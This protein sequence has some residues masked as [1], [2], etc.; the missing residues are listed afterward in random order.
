MGL[1]G[2]PI[3]VE[4]DLLPGLH[5]FTIVGLP[6]KAVE[7]A[8]E[9]VSSAIKNTGFRPPQKKNHR[10]TVNLAPAELQKEGSIFDFAIALGYLLES[11]QINFDPNGKF[12][13]G[14]LA[15]DGTL[16]PIHG[17][18][19]LVLAGRKN[20]LPEIFIPNGNAGEVS[21]IDGIRVYPVSSLADAV[22]HLEG[23]V[24]IPTLPR[25][26][27]KEK[28]GRYPIDF[29]DIKG[30]EA[31]KRAIE[32]AAAGNHHVAFVGPPGTGKTLLARALPSILPELN[33]EE[34]LEITAVHSIAGELEEGIARRRPFRSPH[35]TTSYVALIGG[36]TFPKPGE[37]TLAHRG[38]LFLD[39]FPEFERRVIEA[40]RQ[41]LEDRV[42]SISR[43]RGSMTFPANIMLV[44]AM[45]PCPCGNKGT[46]KEC[47]CAT[48][49]FLQYE[50][51]VSG[52][53]LDRF[54]IWHS[55]PRVDYRKLEEDTESESSKEIR[56]RVSGARRVQIRRA[57]KTNSQLNLRE[58]KKYCALPEEER[59]MFEEAARRLD[60]SARAYHRVLKVART[61]ADLTGSDSIE[62][63]HLFEAIQYRPQK[64]G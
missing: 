43:A 58:I 22:E 16:R 4:I 33:F 25:K 7:E 13:L 23:K 47:V 6:D 48:R 41:P 62:K 49:Q 37:I 15:L 35:H 14:E 28:A 54:D 12:F 38:V 32:I 42:I 17:A 1:K 39:E 40:L 11:K 34:A 3:E 61:I 55:M 64:F 9:R 60:L 31:A 46:Q 2:V 5:R 53:I 27:F 10:I 57:G 36:G 50:R 19:P 29:S 8:K 44:A 18:L 56:V 45:N 26:K 20:G 59:R 63:E 24:E 30:Q 21:L 52:P 51:K